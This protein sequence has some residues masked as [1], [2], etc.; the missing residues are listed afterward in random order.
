MKCYQFSTLSSNPFHRF[1]ARNGR[2]NRGLKGFLRSDASPLA[3]DGLLSPRAPSSFGGLLSPR[4]PSSLQSRLRRTTDHYNPQRSHT[5][6][7]AVA[8]RDAEN[9]DDDSVL[10][11]P[12]RP[13]AYSGSNDRPA[14]FLSPLSGYASRA[15]PPRSWPRSSSMQT[16][17]KGGC[18]R[19]I[20][21]MH[22]TLLSNGSTPPGWCLSAW[23]PGCLS[24]GGDAASYLRMH[25]T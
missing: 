25:T 10:Q 6:T 4:A 21:G 20:R 24:S 11:R 19:P 5:P 23:V 1:D 14:G 16:K 8:R 7:C 12:A 22:P 13:T 9:D 15:N 3:A 2:L 18:R 17:P